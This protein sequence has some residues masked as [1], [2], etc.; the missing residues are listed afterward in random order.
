MAVRDYVKIDDKAAGATRGAFL[1]SLV[2]QARAVLEQLERERAIMLHNFDDSDQQNII[3]TD[4]ET[5][6]GLAAGK[7][8][9]AWTFINGSIGAIT[10]TM[11][12]TDF[13]TMT[14]KMG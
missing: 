12:N 7:G 4:L 1:K 10:G 8:V 5:M 3:W 2:I 6:Y 11:Q 9:T 13:K 14:E